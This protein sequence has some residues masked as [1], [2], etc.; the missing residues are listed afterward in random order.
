MN[1][2]VLFRDPNFVFIDK[3]AGY[4]VHPPENQELARFCRPELVI[5]SQLRR[6]IGC[7]LYPVHRLDVA[8]SGVLAF[9]LTPEAAAGF[10]K[11]S[12]N[13]QI[14]KRYLLLARGWIQEEQRIEIPLES[15]SSDR[16]LDSTT[17]IHPLRHLEVEGSPSAKHPT[18]RYTLA[19]AEPLTGRFH[20]IRRHLNRISHPIIGDNDHGD[21]RQNRFFREKFG[22]QG[23]CLWA[24]ELGFTYALKKYEILS[25]SEANWHSKI[26]I[27]PQSGLSVI[28]PSLSI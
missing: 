12:Q 14:K 9:A 7:Y 18:Q 19:E 1:F 3:P 6:Q 10:Q 5:L 24:V 4:F 2:K 15:D 17:V 23:L 16:L 26:Q 8:T 27:L 13:G 28:H 20:Q 22:V 21:S 25:T 11:C